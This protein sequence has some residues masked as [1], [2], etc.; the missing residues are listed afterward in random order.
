M[1]IA[2]FRFATLSCVLDMKCFHDL[3][4]SKTNF[5]FV[6]SKS[7]SPLLALHLGGVSSKGEHVHLSASL[8]FFL[9]RQKGG[10]FIVNLFYYLY[11]LFANS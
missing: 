1:S 10:E 9:F 2:L 6:G 11:F 8:L 3:S 4:C 7:M 5:S